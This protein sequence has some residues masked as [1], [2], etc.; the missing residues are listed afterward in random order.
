M[1]AGELRFLA[2]VVPLSV[3]VA[4]W[5]AL[6]VALGGLVAWLLAVPA[7]IIL[8]HVLPIIL[9]G[10]SSR[11]QWRLWLGVAVAWAWFHR[12]AGMPAAIFAWIWLAVAAANLACA[13]LLALRR[14]MDWQGI[15]GIAWR[16]GL[17]VGSHIGAVVIGV[18]CGWGW[19]LAAGA[20]LAALYC[21]AVLLPNHQWLGAVYRHADGPLLLTFDDGPHPERTPALLDALDDLGETAV[22]FLIGENARK[23]PDLVREIVRRGH[24]LGNHT[25][26]HPQATFWCAGP[27]RTAREIRGCQDALTAITGV[28]PQWFRAPVGHRNFFTHPVAAACGLH[29]VGWARRGYDAAPGVPAGVLLSRIVPHLRPHDVV[30]LHDGRP[31]APEIATAIHKA[32]RSLQVS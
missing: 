10:R 29:V 31:D 18:M 12:D 11:V 6:G 25:L 32:S 1:H 17:L 5:H 13:C 2:V 23:H 7:A 19:A 26:T 21:L 9:A 8:L 28:A 30:L 3:L 22:F 4:V 24:M 27:W 16:A 14:S 20:L 15:G